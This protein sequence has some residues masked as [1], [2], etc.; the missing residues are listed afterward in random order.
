MAAGIVDRRCSVSEARAT[1]DMF[2]LDADKVHVTWQRRLHIAYINILRASFRD[3]TVL[4][5]F[6][7]S[8]R[9]CEAGAQD[10]E[11]LRYRFRIFTK[12]IT[13]YT[14]KFHRAIVTYEDRRSIYN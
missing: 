9:L 3:I 8:V 5:V 11:Q 4:V 7:L 12:T 1:A 6:V 13:A 2:L 10:A 14:R